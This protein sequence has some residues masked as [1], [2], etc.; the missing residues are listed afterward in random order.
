M[1]PPDS[2]LILRHSFCAR[3]WR[4]WNSQ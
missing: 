2:A 1:L 4:N 3:S